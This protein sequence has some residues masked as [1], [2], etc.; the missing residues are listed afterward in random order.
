MMSSFFSEDKNKKILCAI[1]PH[2]Y[3]YILNIFIHVIPLNNPYIVTSTRMATI[4]LKYMVAS[5]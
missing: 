2:N 5:A 3:Y 4:L 1:I